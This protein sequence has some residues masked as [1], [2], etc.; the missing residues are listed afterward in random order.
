MLLSPRFTN[1]KTEVQKFPGVPGRELSN[2]LSVTKS[3][4]DAA[5]ILTWAGCRTSSPVVL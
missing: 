1:K 3:I 2:L 5:K 4:S